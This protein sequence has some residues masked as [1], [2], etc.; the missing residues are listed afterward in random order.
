MVVSRLLDSGDELFWMRF[1]VLGGKRFHHLKCWYFVLVDGLGNH[2]FHF[3]LKCKLKTFVTRVNIY[4][5]ES[6]VSEF[7]I[8]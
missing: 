7:A 1:D 6:S 5:R 3:H 8:R 4:Q 2:T